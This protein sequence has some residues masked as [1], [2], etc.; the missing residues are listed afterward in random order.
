MEAVINVFES[1]RASHPEKEIRE[2][3]E[4]LQARASQQLNTP[5]TPPPTY[6]PN[7]PHRA[8]SPECRD[9]SV[10][11]ETL[12]S[13]QV[14]ISDLYK[15][16]MATT[17]SR[18]FAK[19]HVGSSYTDNR[20]CKVNIGTLNQQ[21]FRLK[22]N[23]DIV[24]Q[25]E[26]KGG[27]K[28]L[29]N[30]QP[31][32]IMP[33]FKDTQSD[34]QGA[35]LEDL[36]EKQLKSLLKLD[37]PE[38]YLVIATHKPEKRK[39]LGLSGLPLQPGSRLLRSRQLY[40][41][42]Q[43]P[44]TYISRNRAVFALHVEDFHLKSANLVQAGAPKLW[45]IVDPR[46][47]QQLEGRLA[48]DLRFTP[49]CSQ[50]LRHDNLLLPP[51][52]LHKLEISFSVVLQPSGH[53]L[54]LDSGAYHYGVNLGPNIADAI[55]YSEP[56]WTPPPLYRECSKAR[57]CGGQKH[58]TKGGMMMGDGQ[59]HDIVDPDVEEVWQAEPQKKI[60]PTGVSSHERTMTL[61]SREQKGPR[62]SY[63]K[64]AAKKGAA[65]RKGAAYKRAVD[66][67]TYDSDDTTNTAAAKKGA[68]NNDSGDTKETPAN[69]KAAVNDKAADEIDEKS[70]GDDKTADEM[71][72]EAAGDKAADEINK[73]VAG[74][75]ETADEEAADDNET[76]GV[77]R[78]PPAYDRG[79]DKIDM[80]AVS[81][82]NA[83]QIDK[84]T[85]AKADDK[86]DIEAVSHNNTVIEIEETPAETN[87]APAEK[88]DVRE[89]W[90]SYEVEPTYEEGKQV[91]A[92]RWW[93][94]FVKDCQ[95]HFSSF[96]FLCRAEDFE[97][98]DPSREPSAK[99][100]LN[101]AIIF[102]LLQLIFKSDHSV[103][104][105]DSLKLTAAFDK[106]DL[107]KLELEADK[108]LVA[109][110]HLRNHWSLIVIDLKK[111][112]LDV[113]DT[114]QQLNFPVVNFLETSFQL[115][116]T[117]KPV[118]IS[119]LFIYLCVCFSSLTLVSSSLRM[120]IVTTVVSL[121]LPA[122]KHCGP[123]S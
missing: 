50:F 41:G 45:V 18:G 81:H 33:S 6:S 109:P 79:G 122:L 49:R 100:W 70:A 40:A 105:L 52:L 53:L 110:C 71:D 8:R 16:E 48:R 27:P 113:Y 58:L 72:E 19:I 88:E 86:I 78:E 11:E 38:E 75:D 20:G 35:N 55:N 29:S 46:H 77:D 62:I 51:S 121:P 59:G 34:Y 56:T 116:V 120:M 101:D 97:V 63:A 104:L 91:E 60:S 94:R 5:A 43:G 39:Q 66:S 44:Y 98:F 28:Y 69:N 119:C 4:Q 23:T 92:I 36:M 87:G 106:G 82:D 7:T 3:L 61:R 10:S 65:K 64:A 83:E 103:Q 80:E 17:M 114:A 31:P 89:L 30:T 2:L 85:L 67:E 14:D 32:F 24:Q 95:Q 25:H 68:A 74:D 73:K 93:I 54:L 117:W 9:T 90:R 118:S 123:E 22:P 1:F 13:Q 26:T 76:E 108:R 115:T 15:L 84:G 102:H 99:T 112:E 107:T 47:A 111:K 21:L 42:I 37:T 12:C 96:R 57:G